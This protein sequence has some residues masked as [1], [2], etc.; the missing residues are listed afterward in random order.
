M[1]R[2]LAALVIAAGLAFNVPAVAQ[3]SALGTMELGLSMLELSVHREL[4]RIGYGNVDV[5]AL[6]MGQIRQI[7]LILSQS[8]DD[9]AAQ[10]GQIQNVLAGRTKSIQ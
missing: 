4:N 6:S 9:E 3:T 7:H 5:S 2:A 8:E 1:Q 10:H